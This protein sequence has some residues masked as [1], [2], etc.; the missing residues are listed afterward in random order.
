MNMRDLRDDYT[1]TMERAIRFSDAM[2]LA[3]PE[4]NEDQRTVMRTLFA[5]AIWEERKRKLSIDRDQL[6][7]SFMATRGTHGKG[8]GS[9]YW[10][11][12]VDSVEKHLGIYHGNRD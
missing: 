3:L 7:N 5:Q 4:M 6:I 8:S 2:Q 12:L 10:N 1:D 11:L 9:M